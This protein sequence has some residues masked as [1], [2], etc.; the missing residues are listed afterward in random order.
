MIAAGMVCIFRKLDGAKRRGASR[1]GAALNAVNQT[2]RNAIPVD[3]PRL[4][5]PQAAE[6]DRI[7]LGGE[8]IF[9]IWFGS[10]CVSRFIDPAFG[11]DLISISLI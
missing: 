10:V 6:G 9:E 2:V 5:D 3:R 11:V 7:S 4:D 8:P 1:W